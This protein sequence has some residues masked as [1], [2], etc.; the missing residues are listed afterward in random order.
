MRATYDAAET[1]DENYKHW[2]RADNLSPNVANNVGVRRTLRNRARYERANNPYCKGLVSTIAADTI[3]TGPRLSLT[4]PGVSST[5]IQQVEGTFANWCLATNF[6]DKLRVKCE[7]KIVD[8][9][10]VSLLFTNPRVEHPVKLDVRTYEADQC[11]TPFLDSFDPLAVD[12]LRLD[13]YGNAIEYHLLKYRPSGMGGMIPWD[14]DKIDAKAILHWFRPD[15]PGQ[16]RGVSEIASALPLFAYLRR[17]TLASVAAAEIAAMLAG[18]MY[19]DQPADGNGQGEGP[20]LYDAIELVR[21]MLLSLPE[22]WKAE[23]FGAKQPAPAYKEFKGEILCEIA[24][25]VNATFNIIAGNSSGYNY[26]SGRLDHVIYF[27][28]IRVERHRMRWHILDRLLRAWLEEAM[29]V[30]GLLPDGL[31]PFCT[32]TWDWYWDGFESID[33]LKDATSNVVLLQSN[34]TTLKEIY[35]EYG[36]DWEPH[37]RQRARELALCAELGIS[38]VQAVPT[39]TTSSP[40]RKPI[41]DAPADEDEANGED[42]DASMK[43]AWAIG[44]AM[45]DSEVEYAYS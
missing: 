3:G 14:Y 45:L 43:Q 11:T 41:D 29:F 40:K 31:P 2:S 1:T 28:S 24:R 4:I 9:D 22:G 17:Y 35:A 6:A 36:Q 37:L 10:S 27:R 33:P 21:G 16:M 18:I 19:T 30:E 12:G 15:R 23:Q 20:K 7:A 44:E 5:K 26:S 25:S 8:G 39:A 34:Q 13:K 38:P 42:D 32:W